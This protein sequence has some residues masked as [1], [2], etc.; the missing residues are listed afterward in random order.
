MGARIETRSDEGE[1]KD[2]LTL[3]ITIHRQAE[4]TCK[5][6]RRKLLE[7]LKKLGFSGVVRRE[8]VR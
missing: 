6:R 8:T 1:G 2:P 5:E 3:A 4:G 7:E